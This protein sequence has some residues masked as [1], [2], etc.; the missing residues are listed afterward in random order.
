[1][2]LVVSSA[3]RYRKSDRRLTPMLHMQKKGVLY[4]QNEEQE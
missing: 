2:T 1:M 3:S 4:A